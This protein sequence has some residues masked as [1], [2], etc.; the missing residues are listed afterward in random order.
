MPD[1]WSSRHCSMLSIDS[2]CSAA[3]YVNPVIIT[4]IPQPMNI[5]ATIINLEITNRFFLRC[6]KIIPREVWVELKNERGE[7]DKKNDAHPANDCRSPFDFDY[8]SEEFSGK[9]GIEGLD[10]GGQPIVDS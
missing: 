10:N 1:F 8:M 2:R 5:I 9:I 6:R 4:M 3:R 7:P